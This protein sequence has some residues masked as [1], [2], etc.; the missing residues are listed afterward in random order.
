MTSDFTNAFKKL[1]TQPSIQTQELNELDESQSTARSYQNPVD[2]TNDLSQNQPSTMKQFIQKNLKLYLVLGVVAV[3]AGVGTGYGGYKL[4]AQSGSPSGQSGNEIQ[5]VA[6]PTI[7]VGDVFGIDDPD[8]FGDSAQGYL[9][10]G[11]LDGEGSHRLLRP[12]GESQTVYLTSSIT[13]LDP[14]VGMD[15]KVYGETFKGQKAG[16]LMDVGR[17]EVVK[18]SGDKPIT[19]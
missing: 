2:T 5:K 9:E 18:T 10:A 17:V 16:W 14:L 4:Q 3:V 11:G 19:E 1:E 7:S 8:T 13:D 6:G 12:G 15:V